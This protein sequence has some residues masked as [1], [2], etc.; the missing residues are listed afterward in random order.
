MSGGRGSPGRLGL[1]GRVRGA[2][3]GAVGQ[4]PV[5]P[6]LVIVAVGKSCIVSWMSGS[7]PPPPRAPLA[8]GKG[9]CP[10][11]FQTNSLWPGWAPLGFLYFALLL[12]SS[13]FF[14]SVF[15]TV[16]LYF[17]SS[18][19]DLNLSLTCFYFFSLTVRV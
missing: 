1:S 5:K 10:P 9:W 16:H 8:A 18:V 11:L 14:P 17:S 15:S 19:I 7:L 13:A 6:A 4:Q 12:L 3:L 2:S